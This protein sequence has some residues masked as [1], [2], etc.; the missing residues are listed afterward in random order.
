MPLYDFECPHGHR[1]EYF[2]KM[3]DRHEK[4]PCEGKVNQLV[5]DEIA[6]AAAKLCK[7]SGEDTVVIDGT[8]ITFVPICDDPP[9]PTVQL[10][11]LDG[12]L[13]EPH[14]ASAVVAVTQV[15]CMLKATLI[16]GPHSNPAGM[17]DHG[18][19]SNRDAAREGRYD[20]MNPNRR[21]IAKG[22]SW[23]K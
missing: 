7:E 19:A 4:V 13:P 12:E 18:M 1:F 20:P 22:R 10:V 11:P 2:C 17:L 3:A 23:R 5:A 14:V 8:S 16:V 6:D 15:P 21:F 9:V